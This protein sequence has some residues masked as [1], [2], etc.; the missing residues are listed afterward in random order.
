MNS[1][2]NPHS[3]LESFE[4]IGVLI[5]LLLMTAWLGSV[6]FCEMKLF[7][8]DGLYHIRLADMV[9]HGW[10][11]HQ[12]PWLF[13][14]D[15]AQKFT[16][17]HFLFHLLLIPF[18]WLS[19]GDELM[20]GANL[21]ALVLG[22]AALA[23]LGFT[24][25]A[26]KVRFAGLWLATALVASEVFAARLLLP[27]AQSVTLI[28]VTL[29]VLALASKRYKT[30]AILSFF[31][32]WAYQLALIN[33]LV[34]AAFT[35]AIGIKHRRFDTRPLVFCGLAVLAGFVINP[36]TPQSLEFLL[37][38]T[39]F[40][41]GNPVDLKVGGEWKSTDPVE[42]L[43]HL[44]IFHGIYL[45]GILAV[46]RIR[47]DLKIETLA[48]MTIGVVMFAATCHSW[49]FLEYYPFLLVFGSALI[50]RDLLTH[51]VEKQPQNRLQIYGVLAGALVVFCGIQVV[52]FASWLP[53][54]KAEG[55]DNQ[56]LQLA[57][58]WLETHSEENSLVVNSDWG[59]FPFLFYNN[60]HNFYATGLDPN[61]FLYHDPKRFSAYLKLIMGNDPNP[62][63]TLRET[64]NGQY[65]VYR[66][67]QARRSM[68]PER[69]NHMLE[70][71]G[72]KVVYYDTEGVIF[73]VEKLIQEKSM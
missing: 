65:L 66:Y 60:Q 28:F 15:F 16:D 73:G 29:T 38:H 67:N 48:M 17:H 31:F 33:I 25:L 21:G 6:Q 36:F 13:H 51:L 8:V 19:P 45:A 27:R 42:L 23:C 26:L 50:L 7:G 34:G 55:F 1:T 39:L 2:A 54:Q 40:K 18:A 59:D 70:H 43:H 57:A 9:G 24:F 69:W 46:F 72:W 37:T 44:W 52:H 41:V 71:P 47:N 64:L 35:L 20:F 56:R 22:L 53:K 61:L 3:R 14:T 4:R 68:P 62:S 11:S 30:A 5:V 63:K 12:F 49:R 10:F 32:S 58:H